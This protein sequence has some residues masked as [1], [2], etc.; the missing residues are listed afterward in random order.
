MPAIADTLRKL[1]PWHKGKYSV[2]HTLPLSLEPS[3]SHIH[4]VLV[5]R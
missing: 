4:H 1:N 2:L 5:A 3:P